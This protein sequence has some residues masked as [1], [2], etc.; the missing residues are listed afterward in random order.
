MLTEFQMINSGSRS[1]AKHLIMIFLFFSGAHFTSAQKFSFGVRAGGLAT[2]PS[3]ADKEEKRGFSRSVSMGHTETIFIAF[4]MKKDFHFVAEGGY[5]QRR[6]RLKFNN[7]DWV[8][9]SLYNFID[10]SGLLRK[11]FHFQLDKNVPATW[12]VNFGPEVSYWLSG[13]GEFTAGGTWYP[14]TIKFDQEA[15]TINEMAVPNANRWLFGL[16]FG[17]GMKAPLHNHHHIGI[18]LRISSGH[19]YLSNE[20]RFLDPDLG[21]DPRYPVPSFDDTMKVNLKSISLSVNYSLDFDVQQ[22][23]KGRSTLDKK[24]KTKR[25]HH[26]R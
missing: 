8:N 16:A 4:P 14:Y 7:D 13:S 24:V 10:I 15:G 21:V 6:R 20:G 2:W 26:R 1:L 3:F 19:S 9:K 11:S 17:V 18:E 12:Y 23:R 22:S 5:A 25:P